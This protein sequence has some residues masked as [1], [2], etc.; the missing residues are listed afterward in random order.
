MRNYEPNLRVQ[1]GRR[2]AIKMIIRYLN[3][4]DDFMSLSKIAKEIYLCTKNNSRVYEKYLKKENPADIQCP[5]C[6]YYCLGNGGKGCIDKPG[7]Q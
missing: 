5:T 4:K 6:G 1:Y 2:D 3:P 7:L